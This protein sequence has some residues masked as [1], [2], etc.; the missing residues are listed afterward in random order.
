VAAY[1]PASLKV[2]EVRSE[3]TGSALAGNLW[4]VTGVK[5]RTATHQLIT[6]TE[7]QLITATVDR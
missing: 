7:P 3:E 4:Q 5:L 2:V 6:A 1:L